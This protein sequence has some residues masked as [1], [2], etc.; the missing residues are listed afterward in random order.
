ARRILDTLTGQGVAQFDIKTIVTLK[1]AGAQSGEDGSAP[2]LLIERLLD[3]LIA[4][5]TV[6]PNPFSS[7][8]SWITFEGHSACSGRPTR[9]ETYARP[10][11]S[12]SA[13]EKHSP[14]RDSV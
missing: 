13:L 11:Q 6:L 9:Q 4:F 8:Q 12:G 14:N 5:V 2:F 7:H 1:L 3:R 10:Q